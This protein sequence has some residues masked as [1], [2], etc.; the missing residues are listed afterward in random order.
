MKVQSA[1]LA[2]LL[3]TNLLRGQEPALNIAVLTGDGAKEAASQKLHIDPSVQV[4]DEHGKPVE[5]ASVAF[6]LPSQGPS[7]M[8]EN[9][10]HILTVSTDASGRAIAH[11]IKLNDL[12]GEFTIRVSASYQGRTASA[13][14]AVTSVHISRSNGMLGVSTKTWVIVGLCAVAIAGGIVAYK[15]LKPG[16]NPN[17]L[18]ATPG[19]PVVGGPQ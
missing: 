13:G 10:T 3:F 15:E 19:I 18:T 1:F 17:I 2:L 7:G 9:G 5:G 6:T 14:I 12:T 8:F 16:P 11:G 4:N